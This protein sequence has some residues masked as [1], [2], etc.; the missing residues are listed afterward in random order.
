MHALMLFNSAR[1]KSR[2]TTEGSIVGLDK[3]DRS[4]WDKN[5]I[6]LAVDFLNRS[7]GNNLSSYHIE[8]SIAYLHCKAESFE[9]TDWAL[10]VKLYQQ[11]LRDNPNPFAEMNYA[12]ALFY[13]GDRE[14]AFEILNQL[15]KHPFLNQHFLLNA[16]LGKLNLIDGNKTAARKFLDQAIKQTAFEAEKD[17]ILKLIDLT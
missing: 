5:L 14:L 17:L 4:V 2:F 7:R 6:A 3:Q 1:I 15:H 13:S 8:A 9:S 12:I 11:L 10:I 16:S